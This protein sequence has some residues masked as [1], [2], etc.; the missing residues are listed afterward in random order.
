MIHEIQIQQPPQ[1]EE[2]PKI[3]MTHAKPNALKKFT[4]EFN[5]PK[6]KEGEAQ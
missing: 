6:R 2:R 3:S 4:V 1:G 5:Q